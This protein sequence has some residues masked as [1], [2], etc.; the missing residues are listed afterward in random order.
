MSGGKKK[1]SETES[2]SERGVE[3]GRKLTAQFAISCVIFLALLS[4]WRVFSEWV[5]LNL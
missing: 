3:E 1:D 2:E 5:S 4:L